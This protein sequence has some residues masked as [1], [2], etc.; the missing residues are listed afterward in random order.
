[1]DERDRTAPDPAVDELTAIGALLA[2]P[3]PSAEAVEAARARLARVSQGDPVAP[4]RPGRPGRRLRGGPRWL[5][6]VAAAVA[7]A[8]VV[9]ASVAIARTMASGPGSGHVR[10]HSAGRGPGAI[11]QVPK[12]FV[13]LASDGFS[14]P[15]V[16]SATATG[17]VLGSVAVPRPAHVFSMAAS[18]GNGRDFVLAA[19]RGNLVN[20][21]A[22]EGPTRFYRLVLSPSGRPGRLTLLPIPVQ[23]RA[24]SGL[25]LSADGRQLA[26]SLYPP[27]NLR[28]GGT[29]KIFSL[30][31]GAQRDWAWPGPGYVGWDQNSG[32]PSEFDARSMSWTADGRRLLFQ[33]QHGYGGSQTSQVRLLDTTSPGGGLRAA[34]T[35]VPIPAADLDNS[36]RHAP[37][38]LDGPLLITGDGT[39]VVGTAHR[40]LAPV[41]AIMRISIA[42]FSVRTGKLV[43]VLYEQ[44]I[45]YDNGAGLLWANRDGTAVIAGL[46]LRRP[47][48][49]LDESVLGVQTL[50]GFT[51]LPAS[52]QHRRLQPDW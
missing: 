9:G 15:A 46:P 23:T 7:V 51:A 27:G 12:F 10:P 6:P 42:E 43:R 26:V 21:P 4:R 41:A 40:M 14:K 48:S 49:L 11:A 35:L 44:K 3:P 47:R 52:I 1:M 37:F 45:S 20:K 30:A 28:G 24:I 22:S 31:T 38:N 17:K 25:A 32:T 18:A 5:A 33:V 19:S 16:V 8:V 29:I 36:A 2:V 50:T 13:S 39:M 34:S